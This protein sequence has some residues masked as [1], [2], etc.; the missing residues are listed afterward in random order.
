MLFINRG[1]QENVNVFK[2]PGGDGIIRKFYHLYEKDFLEVVKEG[3][4]NFEP[5]DAQYNG[6]ITLLHKCG[7]QDSAC[8]LLNTDYKIIS[9]LLTNRKKPVIKNLFIQIKRGYLF[10]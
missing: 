8:T 5:S 3:F 4:L 10:S 6:M 2:S 9:K 1:S 7:G